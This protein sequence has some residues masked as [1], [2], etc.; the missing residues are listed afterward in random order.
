V[1]I[2][3][4][5]QA[6]LTLALLFIALAVHAAAPAIA[7]Q[8]L[9]GDP[10]EQGEPRPSTQELAASVRLLEPEVRLLEPQVRALQTEQS[11][12]GR[13][14]VSTSSDVLF[15]FGS[16]ELTPEAMAIVQQLA[17]RAAGAPPGEVLVVGH[18][19]GIGSDAD[20]QVLS[21]QR[22]AAVAAVLQARLGPDRP[23]VAEGRGETEPVAPETVGGEDDPAGRALNRRV[24]VSFPEPG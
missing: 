1:T 24:T 6:G 12:E 4:P 9:P 19:D 20:N 8:D 5:A 13:V 21:E 17:E 11:S 22:A 3:R 2:R 7:Q 14:E 23:L 15:A 16:A 18:T 10:L